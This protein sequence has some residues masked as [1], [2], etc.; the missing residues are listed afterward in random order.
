MVDPAL[1]KPDQPR[2]LWLGLAILVTVVIAGL[3]AYWTYGYFSL[4]YIL[5]RDAL[6][7]YWAGYETIV[8]LS[9]IR[10]VQIGAAVTG[11]VSL[12][13]A[14]L[15]RLSD[16]ARLHRRASVGSI[17]YATQPRENQL[18]IL[19]NGVS[20]A[21]S[22]EDPEGLRQALDLR[23]S[24]GPM[25]AVAPAVVGGRV[26]GL[27]FWTDYQAQ[28]LWGVALLLNIALFGYLCAIYPT[29]P[30]ILPF[31]FDAAGEIDRLGPAMNVF[32]IPGHRRARPVDQRRGRDRDPLRAAAGDGDPVG[33]HGP[34]SVLPVDGRAGRGDGPGYR[35]RRKKL[36][37]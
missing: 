35:V 30:P 21:I 19:A 1:A 37:V 6:R 12:P 24:L 8:P 10:G 5:D 9:E 20:Y 11:R 15:A 4:F 13:L 16:W 29:L 31:H 17:F 3:L 36:C 22:P 33:R 2:L 25:H 23:Q 14:A 18:L 34:D 27:S 7:I 26:L 28:G 32:A